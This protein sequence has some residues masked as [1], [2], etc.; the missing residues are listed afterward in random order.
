[1]TLLTT[2]ARLEAAST[3]RAQPLSRVRHRHLSSQPLVLIP[4]TLAGDP[5][6]PLAAL[7]GT[8][9]AAPTLLVVA[10][11]HD[12]QLRLRFLA[13]LARVVLSYI[14]ARQAA[15]EVRPATAKR[16]ER[17]RYA[18]APQVLV[19]NRAALDYLG[20]LGRATRFQSTE[21]PYAVDP[22]V[23][24]LG[25]WLTFLSDR[26]EYPGSALLADLT[27]LL[28]AQWAT[29]QSPLED[30]HLAAQLAWI[31]PPPAMT[32]LQAALAVEDPLRCP[33]A[34]PAT[35]PGFD[36]AILE[37]LVRKHDRVRSNRDQP[38]RVRAAAE[39]TEALRGQLDPTWQSAW[40]A[41]ALLNAL[42]QT[43]SADRRWAEDRDSFTG[44]SLHLANNGLPQPRRD[45][46]VR[47]AARLDQLE[48][49]QAAFDAQRALEDPFVLA[50]L[51]TAGEAFGGTVVAAEPTRTSMSPSGRVILR[52]RFTVRTPDLVRIEPGRALICPARPGQHVKITELAQ[53]G[54]DDTL[55]TLEVTQGMGTPSKPKAGAVPDIGEHVSY[56]LDPGYF[57]QRE[58]P[59]PEQTPWTHGGPPK[60][61]QAE[62]RNE[63]ASA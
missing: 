37:P 27:T 43:A 29:G 48:R 47:A 55:V 45:P 28:A 59:P 24:V 62:D 18:D 4:L 21:G 9:R 1:M 23:P 13:D 6:T 41:I 38:G 56:T 36:R 61:P 35:D 3:G 7:A 39:I 19:P 33:P 30:V 15:T 63:V 8:S 54:G 60:P 32:G 46:A 17:R 5:A 51:R 49:A 16:E 12:R 58:F 10:Q 40:N 25:R 44:Y 57:A 50:E 52:P 11:P 20:L 42:P 22:V 53:D 34:G 2:L 31:D 26:A 14:T